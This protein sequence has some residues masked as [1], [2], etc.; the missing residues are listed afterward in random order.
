MSDSAPARRSPQG[1]QLD[2]HAV[3]GELTL[4]QCAAC[5]AVQYPPRELCRECLAGELN[6]TVLPGGGEL[7]AYSE[8]QHSL[9]PYFRDQLPWMLGSVRLDCGPVVLA[10]L[11]APCPR[12][13]SRVEVSH[14]I[15][16]GGGSI[17]QAS[18]T[19]A[20]AA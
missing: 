6:W 2:E 19:S 9:E 3:A 11:R 4:Q 15:Q 1:R 18:P 7:L 10:W 5:H 12:G 20:E 8:L 17:L 13:D 16:A 14:H